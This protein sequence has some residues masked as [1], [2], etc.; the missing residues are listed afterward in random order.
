MK[1]HYVPYV[2]LIHGRRVDLGGWY[3]DDDGTRVDEDDLCWICE[4]PC[5][6]DE[7]DSE[8]FAIHEDCMIDREANRIDAMRDRWTGC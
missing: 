7:H 8:G 6:P 4:K 5:Q 3:W 2:C 1:A